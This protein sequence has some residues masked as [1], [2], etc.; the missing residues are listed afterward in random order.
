LAHLELPVHCADQIVIG[1]NA[2]WILL[3]TI[4][5]RS[6]AVVSMSFSGADDEYRA[7]VRAACLA[8]FGAT[9]HAY[10]VCMRAGIATGFFLCR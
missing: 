10:A 9:G 6:R 4:N 5:R 8:A 3:Q 2:T 7:P 1:Q